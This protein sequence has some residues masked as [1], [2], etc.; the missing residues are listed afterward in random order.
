M[1]TEQDILIARAWYENRE[2]LR[3]RA[4][5]GDVESMYRYA[6]IHCNNID[7]DSLK[8]HNDNVAGY[9]MKRAA[10]L[11]H[12][13]AMFEYA[14]QFLDDDSSQRD[15][16]LARAAL[17]GHATALHHLKIGRWKDLPRD[18]A[19]LVRIA[20]KALELTPPETLRTIKQHDALCEH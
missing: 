18:K 2:S 17:N 4:A 9:W 19:D 7:V 15:V 6:F 8:Y 14:D 13:D 3:E 12:L 16:Y 5:D 1:P 20:L 11:G 10:D